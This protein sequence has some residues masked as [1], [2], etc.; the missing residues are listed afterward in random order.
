MKESDNRFSFVPW[1]VAE[2][3]KQ[4]IP[5][6]KNIPNL[7]TKMMRM[8]FSRIQAKYDGGKVYTDV[9]VQHSVP[10]G[11]LRGDAEWFLKEKGTGMYDKEL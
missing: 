4:L 1:K 3:A 5:L 11:D 2:A 7:M 9:F 10:I 6:E 8:Y